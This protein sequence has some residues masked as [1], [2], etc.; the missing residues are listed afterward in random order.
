MTHIY[1]HTY[2]RA[3][4]DVSR[5]QVLKQIVAQNNKLNADNRT[6]DLTLTTRFLLVY[7]C[8]QYYNYYT[9]RL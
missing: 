9:Y 3:I 4:Y 8:C 2:L 7:K 5:Y 6:K 1:V